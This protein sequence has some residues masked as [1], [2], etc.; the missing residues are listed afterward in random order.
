MEIT[1]D[2]LNGVAST[3]NF[4]ASLFLSLEA[5]TIA[6]LELV[7]N[8]LDK[9]IQAAAGSKGKKKFY[10]SYRNAA[11]LMII[12]IIT[13]SF[14]PFLAILALSAIGWSCVILLYR[15]LQFSIELAEKHVAGVLGFIGLSIGYCIQMLVFI[16]F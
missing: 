4:I 11:F 3:I 2:L 16:F 8:A 7:S 5:I 15:F 14:A 10:L 1:A 9:S 12:G 13:V 6:R